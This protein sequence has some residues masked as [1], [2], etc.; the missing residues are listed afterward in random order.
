MK[1]D[2]EELEILQ[3][4]ENGEFK[5]LNNILA[6]REKLKKLAENTLKKNKRIN[7]RISERDLTAIKREANKEGIPYQT[8][9]SSIVHKYSSGLLKHI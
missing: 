7:F 9:I 1:L 4:F 6:E 5:S 2:D 3:D 8:L